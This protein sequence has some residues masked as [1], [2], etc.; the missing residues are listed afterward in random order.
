MC[1]S[2]EC[3][4]SHLASLFENLSIDCA[5]DSARCCLSRLEDVL[6]SL[7]QDSYFQIRCMCMCAL[8]EDYHICMLHV[9]I[10]TYVC[11]YACMH[12]C[13]HACMYVYMYTGKCMTAAPN[14]AIK[15]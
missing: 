12:A 15:L 6:K 4:L 3:P 2:L 11:M 1:K 10:Y 5:S 13:M 7:A 8:H 14:K 9:C